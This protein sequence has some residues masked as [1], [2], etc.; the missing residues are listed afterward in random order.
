MK[1][2]EVV[3]IGGGVIGSSIAWHLAARGMRNVVVLDRA[4]IPGAGSTSKATGG[5]RAQF[6]T[7]VN[8]RMSL[9]SREKLLRFE[10]ETGVDSGYRPCGYLFLAQADAEMAILAA[11]NALQQRE[12]VTEAR[13]VTADEANSI[14]PYIA[15][16]SHRGGTFSPT[17]GF[18]RPMEIL[19]GYRE[20]ATRLGVLFIDGVRAISTATEGSRVRS[21]EV[22]GEMYTAPHFVNAAGAWAGIVA[23]D[24]FGIDV[25]VTPLRRCV[26]PTVPMSA[27]PDSMPMTIWVGDGFHFRVRDGRAL[28]LWPD[29][30]PTSFAAKVPDAWIDRV[31][32]FTRERVPALASA[33]LDR[34]GAWAGLYEMSPDGHAIVGRAAGLENLHLANGSS[35]HG[36]M[37]SPAIGQLVAEE[38][39]D[40]RA[41]AV[42]IHA[43]RPTRFAEGDAIAGSHLL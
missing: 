18:I 28:L 1:T 19:R 10:D 37:H 14:Q 20:A 7:S 26:V 24:Q 6:S 29:A 39:V 34:A 13:I 40:G 17:D 9:L 33:A 4:P 35:G 31:E 22:D 2:A 12:G 42:D 15:R 30:P 3:I 38:I 32:R 8:I 41:T 36:V 11:A 27:L 43:L 25:P 21:V 5:F 16:D 23:R